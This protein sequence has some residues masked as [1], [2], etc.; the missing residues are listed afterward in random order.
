MSDR[1]GSV[2]I[3]MAGAYP[4]TLATT[5]AMYTE[6]APTMKIPAMIRGR[7]LL[8]WPMTPTRKPT[9]MAIA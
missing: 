1:A 3:A 2:S 9:A 5:K 8:M 7:D 4:P 6:T